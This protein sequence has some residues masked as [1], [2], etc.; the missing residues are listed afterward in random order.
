MS[1]VFL[2]SKFSDQCFLEHVVSELYDFSKVGGLFIPDAINENKRAIIE[3][4]MKSI[5]EE[6][7][8]KLEGKSGNVYFDLYQYDPI[9]MDPII[10]LGFPQTMQFVGE[11]NRFLSRLG[12]LAGF[13][14]QGT[15]PIFHRY[16][17][18]NYVIR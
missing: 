13:K 17:A 10:F 4:E 15:S 14:T 7:F 1:D 18:E 11:F 5:P 12:N 16:D 2:D 8:E 6:S 3:S 9:N